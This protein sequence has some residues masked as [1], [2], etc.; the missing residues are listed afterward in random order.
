[1]EILASKD[2]DSQ[3]QEKINT[4]LN[5]NE[6]KIVSYNNNGSN[7][8]K[9]K[10]SKQT[11]RVQSLKVKEVVYY[12]SEKKKSYKLSM[13]IVLKFILLYLINL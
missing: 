3:I 13:N 4:D 9:N 11:K 12:D 8:P 2:D 6:T 10:S 1:M 7:S 5:N